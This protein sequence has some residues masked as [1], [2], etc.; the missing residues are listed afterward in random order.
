VSASFTARARGLIALLV[1]FAVESAASEYCIS[2]RLMPCR[3]SCD[4]RGL[5]VEVTSARDSSISK[6]YA[7]LRPGGRTLSQTS[8]TSRDGTIRR[9]KI[10]TLT[11]EKG[12]SVE[13]RVTVLCDSTV[14]ASDSGTIEI[15][16]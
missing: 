13:Y 12:R 5:M 7:V 10:E 3:D 14:V 8:E 1:A 6:S 9:V 16:P 15:D 4:P 2:V 11:D